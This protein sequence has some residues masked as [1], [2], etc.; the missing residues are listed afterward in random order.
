[1]FAVSLTSP[2]GINPDPFFSAARG[3]GVSGSDAK[4]AAIFAVSSVSKP[5]FRY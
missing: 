3:A 4:P 1:M 2:L 5:R